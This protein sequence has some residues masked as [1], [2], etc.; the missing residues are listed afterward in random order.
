M[1]TLLPPAAGGQ[2]R[3]PWELA[4]RNSGTT[5]ANLVTG[6]YPIQFRDVPGYLIV[7]LPGHVAVPD[8][9]G[10][11]QVTNVYYATVNDTN[12]NGGSGSLTVNIGPSPP[13]G[14]GWRFLGDSTPFLPP[15]Y[16]PTSWPTLT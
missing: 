11:I 2:W 12:A 14:A 4:W 7:P 16:A 8:N 5:A 15:G 3:F 9:G 6:E 1:V 10:T 13:A